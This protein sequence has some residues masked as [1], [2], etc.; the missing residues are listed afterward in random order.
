MLAVAQDQAGS[1]S[2]AHSRTKSQPAPRTGLGAVPIYSMLS[3]SSGREE[4]LRV[5]Y[6]QRVIPA[7]S[8]GSTSKSDT[9]SAEAGEKPSTSVDSA[10]KE[11]F[12]AEMGMHGI[13]IDIQ[14]G[15]MV[16]ATA[17]ML[18]EPDPFL[19]LLWPGWPTDLPTPYVVTT[20][21]RICEC[22]NWLTELFV[23]CAHHLALLTVFEK[24]PMRHLI[25]KPMFMAGESRIHSRANASQC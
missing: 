15:P 8:A 21:A 25:Y 1:S 24:H 5:Q 23:L 9:S 16:E 20:L 17:A 4:K 3:P 13:G 22:K 10:H 19:E 12:D 2:D 14:G 18:N 7:P 6:Q 11:L